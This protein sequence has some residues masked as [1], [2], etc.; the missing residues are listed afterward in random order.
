MAN[1]NFMA[2]AN[3]ELNQVNNTYINSR[4]A[5][6]GQEKVGKP[7]LAYKEFGGRFTDYRPSGAVE[8]TWK[9]EFN[10]PTNTNFFRTSVENDAINLGNAQNSS[11]VYQTQTLSNVGN[12][13]L[14]NTNSDCDALPGT[15]CNRN[16]EN[17]PDAHGNQSGSYCSKT[18]YPE[19]TQNG[20]PVGPQGGGTYH[21]LLT[22]QNGIGKACTTNND[23][24]QG[25]YCNNEYD[26]QGSNLQQTGYC[27]MKYTCPDGS[28]KYLGTPYNSGIPLVPPSEQNNGGKGYPSKEVC[29]NDALA[30]QDCVRADNNRWYAVYPGYCPIPSNLRKGGQK[31]SSVRTSNQQTVNQGF[32]IPSFATNQASSTGSKVQAFSTAWNQPSSVKDGTN[33][34]LAYSMS[35]NPLPKNLYD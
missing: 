15:T 22:N 26:F 18:Y 35:I 20:N 2:V 30:Q 16:Y 10:L 13:N 7:F 5:P 23:C 14:C 6:Q 28:T 11:W 21:R 24:G 12:Y 25:Y 32:R 4:Y 33:E 8:S 17:W 34:A 3:K 1:I 29:L 27:S 31:F 9:K 19:L